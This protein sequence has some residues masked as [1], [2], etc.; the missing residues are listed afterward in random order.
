MIATQHA[1]GRKEYY[2]PRGKPFLQLTAGI[3]EALI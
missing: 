1:P 2:F 3:F